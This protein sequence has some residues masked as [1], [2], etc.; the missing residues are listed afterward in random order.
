MFNS[1][2]AKRLSD[3]IVEQIENAAGAG[4]LKPGD[5]LPTERELA[6]LFRVSRSCVREGVRALEFRGLVEVRRGVKGGQFIRSA[7]PRALAKSLVLL[8]R[9]QP[10]LPTDFAEAR[11]MIEPEGARVAAARAT[12]ADLD[13][14]RQVVEKRTGLAAGSAGARELDITF[15]RRVAYMT[16]NAVQ[17][18]VVNT[19]M[20]LESS[21]IRSSLLVSDEDGAKIVLAHRRILSALVVHD[22]NAAY[23]RMRAH[24]V[25]LQQSLARP[26]TQSPTKPVA[27]SAEVLRLVVAATARGS[28]TP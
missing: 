4:L 18:L 11:V 3:D 12:S 26:A 23:T 20:D 22:G 16:K 25:E 10:L 1:V 15:H 13:E 5:R 7:D 28:V 24:L 6:A 2:R 9:A 14:L 27:D 17:S 19:L 21:V 8:F